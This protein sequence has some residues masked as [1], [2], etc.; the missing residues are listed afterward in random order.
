[1][2]TR[3][4]E[5]S[6]EAVGL[7]RVWLWVWWLWVELMS[8]VWWGEGA[9]GWCW[10]GWWAW[11]WREEPVCWGWRCPRPQ[12]WGPLVAGPCVLCWALWCPLAVVGPPCAVSP[13]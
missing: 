6:L 4:Q 5:G 3:G 8:G 12:W 10:S 7:G 1:M 2:L 13:G 11:P 9:E